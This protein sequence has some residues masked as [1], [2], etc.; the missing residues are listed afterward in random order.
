MT[1]GLQIV[2]PASFEGWDATL[3]RAGD[4]D[5]FHTAGWCRVLADSYSYTPCTVAEIRGGRLAAALPLMEIDS[6]LTGRRGVSLPFTDECPAFAEGEDARASAVAEAGRLGRERGWKYLEIR[7]GPAPDGASPSLH[8]R[9]H[10]LDLDPGEERLFAGVRSETRTAVRKAMHEG[11]RVNIDTSLA[12]VRTFYGLNC[13]T[14]RGHGLPPQPYAFFAAVHRHLL[15]RGLGFVALATLRG[16]PAAGAVFLHF[17]RRAIYKYGASDRALRHLRG[18]N[19]VMWEAIRWLAGS[20]FASLSMGKTSLRHEGLRQ[21]KLGWGARET[22][23]EYFK[24]DVR[25]GAYVG[26]DDRVEGWHNA[27]FRRV[28]LPL[29]RLAGSVLYRHMA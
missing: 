10:V 24:Y 9:G 4:A 27:V 16:R 8:F 11:L 12:A 23:V 13:L 5:V 2:D 3:L 20:G 18:N 21:F 14:R 25:R 6:W 28:P 15:A 19:L 17:G 26:D 7:G 22:A 1:E 29:S